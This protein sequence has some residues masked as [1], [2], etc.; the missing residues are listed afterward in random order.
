MVINHKYFKLVSLLKIPSD[1][2]FIAASSLFIAAKL[3]YVPVSLEK[4]AN[5][6][7]NVEKNRNPRTM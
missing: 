2:L 4:L 5:A 7:F 3:L 6:L 1:L